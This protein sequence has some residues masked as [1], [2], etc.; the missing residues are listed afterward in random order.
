MQ[1]YLVI[2]KIDVADEGDVGLIKVINQTELSEIKSIHTGFGNMDG[3][4]YEF[5]ESDAIKITEEEFN[6]L[7]KLGLTNLQF[8][9]CNL[10]DEPLE[11]DSE[12]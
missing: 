9:Y 5:D 6:V 10:S 3:E 8:G 12:D 7:K 1:K 11:E 2:L 4:N